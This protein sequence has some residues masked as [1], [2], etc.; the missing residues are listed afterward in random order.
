M[1][2]AGVDISLWPAVLRTLDKFDKVGLEGVTALL[3]EG[4]K[5]DSSAFIDGHNLP[6]NQILT[7]TSALRNHRSWISIARGLSYYTGPRPSWTAIT[8]S[9]SMCPIPLIP[10][11]RSASKSI[12]LTSHQM[13][14]HH[15]NECSNPP[16]DLGFLKITERDEQDLLG[17]A[18]SSSDH[19][20]IL[21]FCWM[22]FITS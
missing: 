8:A 16:A 22:I 1:H 13:K 3:K 4:Y 14:T 17:K 15:L 12:P 2:T 18:F 9:M 6:D 11:E 10:T 5:D 20:Q 21:C 19:L 7:I